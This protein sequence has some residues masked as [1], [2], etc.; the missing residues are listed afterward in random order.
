MS[1]YVRRSRR[2]GEQETRRAPSEE[3]S[4]VGDGWG[5][6]G[7]LSIMTCNMV[8]FGHY[9]LTNEGVSTNGREVI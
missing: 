7:V 5:R 9:T 8:A 2:Q 3:W 1:H 6:I 4:K